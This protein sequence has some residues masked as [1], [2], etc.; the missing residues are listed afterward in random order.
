MILLSYHVATHADIRLGESFVTI[1]TD[2]N[3]KRCLIAAPLPDL[4][5]WGK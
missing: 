5:L 4:P 3:K 1:I 2:V